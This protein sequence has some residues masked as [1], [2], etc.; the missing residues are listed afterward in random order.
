MSLHHTLI[1]GAGPAAI[2]TAVAVAKSW[3]GE[4]SIVNRNGSHSSE[5]Q[6]QLMKSGNVI[7]AIAPNRPSLSGEVKITHFY[8]EFASVEDRFDAMIVCVPS[9]SY[10]DVLQAL[11]IEKITQLQTIILLSPIIGSNELVNK[12]VRESGR[13]IEVISFSTYFAATKFLPDGDLVSFTKAVKKRI[14]L[15]TNKERSL[16]LLHVERLLAEAGIETVVKE[17]PIDVECRNITTYVHPAF[18]INPFS[19]NEIFSENKSLKSLYKLYPEGP[20]TQE[21]IRVMVKLWKEISALVVEIGGNPINLLQFLNDDNYPVHDESLSRSDLESFRKFEPVKQEYLLYI[22]YAS[23]LIDPFS[24]PDNNGAYFDFSKVPYQ[25]ISRT[26]SEEW[27]VPRIPFED[28]MNLVQ[29]HRMAVERGI[30]TPEIVRLIQLFE[31]KVHEWQCL[32]GES[33]RG[34]R[35]EERERL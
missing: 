19:L 22:R 26:A 28:Y 6:N 20:I 25:Q 4:V 15:A 5:V 21:T 8:D 31:K 27:S 7:T 13:S 16:H 23:I 34:M 14:Y 35:N 29:M 32:K 1:V 33:I 10:H 11:R 3:Q 9:Y 30:N 2:Q 24:K 12:L 18:F 17:T